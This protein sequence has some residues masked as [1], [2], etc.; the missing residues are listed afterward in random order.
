MSPLST[1]NV[2]ISAPVLRARLASRGVAEANHSSALGSGDA[3]EE[4]R[5]PTAERRRDPDKL[6][7]LGT[8]ARE[9]LWNGP[10][11][12]PAF[13]AQVLGQ[14]MMDAQERA[15]IRTTAAYRD[16]AQIAP[17]AFFDHGT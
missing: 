4:R 3:S 13:V 12:N 9:P 5:G 16:A 14:V 10:R 17:G 1:P 6:S 8:H 15:S 2:T 11:L 7:Q